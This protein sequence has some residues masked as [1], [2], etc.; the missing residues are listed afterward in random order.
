M[1]DEFINLV[2]NHYNSKEEFIPLH[3]P[4]FKGNEV[5]Y[6]TDTIHSTF[7]SSVGSY[8]DRFEEM[9]K[10]ITGSKY[11]IATVNGTSALH[12]A[13]HAIGIGYGDEVITQAL[14]FVATANAIRYTGADPIF[15]DVDLDSMSLSP[16]SVLQFL[17]TNCESKNNTLINMEFYIL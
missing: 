1:I 7:V 15:L 12:I 8:V 17:E 16:V 4:V 2:R 9:I 6:V 11:A 13:L 3:A 5:K 14:C 10:T